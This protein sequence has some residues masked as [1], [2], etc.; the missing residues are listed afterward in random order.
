MK[1]FKEEQRFT[2]LWLIVLLIVSALMPFVILF[3]EYS[4]GK[5]TFNEFITA[6]FMIVL[7][8]GLIFLFKLKTR[9]DATGIHY[10]FFPFHFSFKTISW[11]E[12]NQAYVRKYSPIGDYGG[13][14]IKGGAFWDSGKGKA[15]NV[16]GDIGIQL[17]LKNGK[18]LLI[19][20][21]KENEAKQVL[22]TYQKQESH[23]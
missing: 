16:S 11:T 19:G 6:M 14:G 5:M 18:K 13:W 12:I 1:V 4:K 7:A 17:E 15:I 3:S 8:T 21:Q 2:Q 10:Q 9:I 22:K 20:T 23:A